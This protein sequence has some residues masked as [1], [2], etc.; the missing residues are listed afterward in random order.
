[1]QNFR[2]YN[3]IEYTDQPAHG[4]FILAANTPFDWRNPQNNN[5]WQ[6]VNGVNNPCPSGYRVPT[7]T[8]FNNERLSWSVNTS[9]GAFA[10]LL[11]LPV[12]GYRFYSLGSLANVGTFG[13]YWSATVSSTNVR[14][15]SFNSS[16]ATIN[17]DYRAFG[18]SVR[19]IKN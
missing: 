17:T 1:M 18:F 7:E 5:L 2:N 19:C 8:E 11:K 6:G 10:S 3:H 16:N 14:N 15:L 12:A 13:F 4:N 9:A